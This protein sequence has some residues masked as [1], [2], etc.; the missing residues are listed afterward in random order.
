[1]HF[2]YIDVIVGVN[3]YKLAKEEPVEVL[4]ID[5]SKVLEVQVCEF[6]HLPHFYLFK[7]LTVYIQMLEKMSK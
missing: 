4:S 2:A 7:T 1:M 3:K 5:N 6:C